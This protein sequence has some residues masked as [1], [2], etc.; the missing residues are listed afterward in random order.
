MQLEAQRR[1]SDQLEVLYISK[2]ILPKL[3]G[4]T[5]SK[6]VV[7]KHSLNFKIIRHILIILVWFTNNIEGSKELEA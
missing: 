6:R 3:F 5:V 7:S 2:Y 4:L 1:M